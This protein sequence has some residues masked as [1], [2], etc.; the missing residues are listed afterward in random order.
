MSAKQTSIIAAVA[1]GT[2]HQ[3]AQRYCK[4]GLALALYELPRPGKERLL[5]PRQQATIVAMVCSDPPPGRARWTVR[6]VA[7]EA[8]SRRVVATVGRETI[9][10]L[11]VQHE[12]KPWREK[13]VVRARA[14]Q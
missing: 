1:V 8:V 12:L 2:V 5:A 3:V 4:G 13:N 10:Q 14:R 11:L 6:L 9:R 7:K